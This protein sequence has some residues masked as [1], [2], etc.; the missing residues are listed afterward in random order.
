MTE[1]P[2]FQGEYI[3]DIKTMKKATPNHTNQK[4]L[5]EEN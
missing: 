1:T 4:L 5:N 3:P 2:K